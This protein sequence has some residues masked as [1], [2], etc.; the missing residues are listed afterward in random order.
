MT[1]AEIDKIISFLTIGGAAVALFWVLRLVVDGK[2]HSSSE[3]DGLRSD[4]AELLRINQEMTE[5]LGSAN[6]QLASLVD[7]LKRDHD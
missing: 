2:L 6:E 5:A 1:G 4:K 3:V 7:I